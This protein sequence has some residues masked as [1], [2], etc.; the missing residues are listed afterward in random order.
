MSES[1]GGAPSISIR[2]ASEADHAAV[3]SLYREVWMETHAPLQ[4]PEVA[5]FRDIEFFRRRVAGLGGTMLVASDAAGIAGFAHWSGDLLGQLYIGR[6]L[7]GG[8][9][10]HRLLAMAEAGV[11]EAGLPLIRL[12]CLLGNDAARAFY[13]R[14]R[15]RVRQVLDRTAETANGPVP[16]RVWEMVKPLA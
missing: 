14:R 9:I 15:W 13:E 8:G 2:A 10:G 4:P 5:A 6:R 3:A 16:T 7:R 12:Y 11:K 1:S